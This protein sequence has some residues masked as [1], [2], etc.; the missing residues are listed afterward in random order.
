MELRAPN[1]DRASAITPATPHRDHAERRPGATLDAWRPCLDSLPHSLVRS[2]YFIGSASLDRRVPISPNEGRDPAV[3]Y[4]GS[5][6]CALMGRRST[7]MRNTPV[8]TGMPCAEIA[9]REPRAPRTDSITGAIESVSF[10]WRQASARPRSSRL[11][12]WIYGMF[13]VSVWSEVR[14]RNVSV[15]IEMKSAAP[16]ATTTPP[17]ISHPPSRDR[18]HPDETLDRAQQTILFSSLLLLVQLLLNQLFFCWIATSSVTIVTG[19]QLC[20]KKC[21]RKPQASVVQKS[22]SV[23]NWQKS[24]ETAAHSPSYRPSMRPE[25]EYRRLGCAPSGRPRGSASARSRPP[26]GPPAPS[27]W[28]G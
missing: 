21:M 1:P 20:D 15:P 7:A 28:S 26:P 27:R 14:P 13:A 4:P 12:D 22:E 19:S 24:P 9:K 17:T 16:T 6:S 25:K 8:G 10:A 2:C 5:A 3:R 23:R 18:S 11:R